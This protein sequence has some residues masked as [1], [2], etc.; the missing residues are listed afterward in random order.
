MLQSAIPKRKSPMR[1][2][3]VILGLFAGLLAT[4]ALAASAGPAGA[5]T[6]PRL[7]RRAGPASPH[8]PSPTKSHCFGPK[9]FERLISGEAKAVKALVFD[10][11]GREYFGT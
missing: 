5:A 1:R 9:G 11:S 4:A 7:K 8:C 6:A 10:A 2:I 3:P